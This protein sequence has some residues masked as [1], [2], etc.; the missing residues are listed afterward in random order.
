MGAILSTAR[1]LLNHLLPFTDRSTPLI[2]DLIHTAIL[3][4]TLYFAPALVERY[5]THQFD[6][7]IPSAEPNHDHSDTLDTNP[8]AHIPLDERLVLQPDSDEENLEPPPLAPTPPPNLNPNLPPQPVEPAA[9]QDPVPFDQIPDPQ[10]GPADG[11]RATAQNRT[12]GAKKAKSLA[13]KDQRRAYHEF[14]R[15]QA[16]IRRQAEA[17]GKEEREAELAAEKA[18]RAEVEREILERERLEREK[19]KEEERREIEE[20]RGARERAMETVRREIDENR[21]VNLVAVAEREERDEVWIEKLVRASGLLATPQKTPGKEVTMITG[22]G[23]LVRIDTDLMREAYTNA[24]AH[25]EKH[26]G[27]IGFADFGGIL[28]TSVRA[29]AKA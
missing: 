28:E 8:D 17:A 26:N 6:D 27:K 29:R 11:P 23:W 4:G 14:H 13:R 3:C 7:R 9:F 15:Q 22:G 19:R 2:Q 5:Q 16:E 10:D 18:R 25:G 21:A 1:Y 20:E 12:I 24:V